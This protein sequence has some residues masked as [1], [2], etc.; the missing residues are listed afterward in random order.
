MLRL[1]QIAQKPQ[2]SPGPSL[3]LPFIVVGI[4]F[5]ILLLRPQQKQRKDHQKLLAGVKTGDRVITVGGIYGLVTNV[6]NG[7]VVLK[8]AEGV[9]IEVARDAIRGVV[10]GKE[11][12]QAQQASEASNSSPRR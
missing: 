11:G 4:L 8:I 7:I 6:K 5:Y 3:W 2:P 12:S 1:L 10:N 9:K